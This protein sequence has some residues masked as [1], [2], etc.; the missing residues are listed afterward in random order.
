MIARHT[1]KNKH[2]PVLQPPSERRLAPCERWRA[3]LSVAQLARDVTA[4]AGDHEAARQVAH[5]LSGADWA[6]V[7]DTFS[8]ITSQAAKTVPMPPIV[9]IED[10]LRELWTAPALV[11]R[12]TLRRSRTERGDPLPV[13]T[14]RS[15]PIVTVCERLGFRLHRCGRD[16]E[17]TCPSCGTESKSRNLRVYPRSRTGA[18]RFFCFSCEVKGDSIALMMLVKKLDFA[19]AVREVAA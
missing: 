16:Y 2:L 17:M 13:E 15:V 11:T 9:D 19:Q 8:I 1:R 18:G 12:R 10:Q 7:R 6:L 14:A 3:L 4:Y 5:A